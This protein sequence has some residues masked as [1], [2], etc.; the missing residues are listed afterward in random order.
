MRK[1]IAVIY[2]GYSSE[3]DI[4]KKSA[5]TIYS[6]L[7]TEIYEPYLVEISTKS[8]YVHIRGGVAPIDK[9]KFT[10][11]LN[12]KVHHFDL[13]FISIHGTPGEDGKLQAY[14][15]M[16]G[17]PYVNSEP[18]SSGLSFNK[19]ACNSFLRDFGI[20]TAKAILLRKSDHVQPIQIA[21]ELGF[22]CFVKPNDGGSSYGISKVKTLMEMPDA[23]AK[24]FSEGKEVVVESFIQGRELTC[25]LYSNGNEIIVF[26]LT[27]I[28][29]DND[30]FDYD[31]KYN[32][33]S[34]EIT[35]AEISKDL[36]DEIQSV[37]KNIYTRLDLNALARIDYIVTPDND[38][39]LIEVNTI[40]GMTNKSLVPQQ[41]EKAGLN[42]TTVLTEI[43][44]T[45]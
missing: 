30:F 36:S 35:P 6:N 13:A 14:F 2:G 15:D 8:W 1:K 39:Y 42:L 22:P 10:Y 19:W 25:G 20:S 37:S 29:T 26:P 16:I 32:G 23:I 11:L 31:A 45:I 43:I 33:K 27:E 18:L 12:D 38:I 7:D 5:D 28:V 3:F 4:S 41:I 17:L 34:K 44:N 40:P 24:A 9:N 21:D